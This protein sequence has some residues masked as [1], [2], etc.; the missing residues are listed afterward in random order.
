M[1]SSKHHL[2]DKEGSVSFK[3][4]GVQ[5]KTQNLSVDGQGNYGFQRVVLLP[6][7]IR[8][9]LG[10][11]LILTVYDKNGTA[12][13]VPIGIA[14]LKTD[15]LPYNF[16]SSSKAVTTDLKLHQ[17]EREEGVFIPLALGF[18]CLAVLMVWMFL[19]VFL[20]FR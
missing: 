13:E 18:S 11:I 17:P 2:T 8:D 14:K 15:R 5:I 1:N 7:S 3:F 19:L 10:Q 12:I 4:Y 16:K 20:Q 9:V 6:K